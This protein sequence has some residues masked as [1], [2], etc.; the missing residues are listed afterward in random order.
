[1]AKYTELLAEYLESGGAL[2]AAFSTI[3]GFTD[4]FTEHYADAEIGFETEALFALKLNAKANEVIPEYA[5]RIQQRTTALLSLTDP[6]KVR[7]T[8]LEA[9]EKSA[10]QYDLP[11]NAN[12]TSPTGKTHSDDY[13]DVS[14][15]TESGFTPDEI[16]RLVER[17][18]GEIYNIK[19]KLLDEFKPCFMQ[20]Y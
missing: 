11:F 6:K 9:D 4:L 20:V 5:I 3:S 18:Q 14:T 19:V 13:E 2:P 10:Q 17:L 7:E 15:L 8:V 1:M 12:D 16:M